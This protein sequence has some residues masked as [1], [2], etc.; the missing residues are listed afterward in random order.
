MPHHASLSRRAQ[1]ILWNY[2]R[3]N[4]C[5]W[6]RLKEPVGRILQTTAPWGPMAATR[7]RRCAQPTYV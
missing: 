5:S 2:H 1:Q 3:I 6:R 7:D 4:V